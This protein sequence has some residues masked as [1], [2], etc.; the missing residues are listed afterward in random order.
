MSEKTLTIK[1]LISAI[2][3]LNIDFDKKRLAWFRETTNKAEKEHTLNRQNLNW[4]E[5]KKIKRKNIFT[6]E[7]I[8][9]FAALTELEIAS[10]SAYN[11]LYNNTP[12]YKNYREWVC[13]AAKIEVDYL[14]RMLKERGTNFSLT[15]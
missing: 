11:F 8:K 6:K 5:R 10:V 13:T 2:Q 3:D 4:R 1:I 15:T 9:E 14:M 7:E 12:L